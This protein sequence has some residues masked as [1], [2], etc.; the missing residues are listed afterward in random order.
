MSKVCW[1]MVIGSAMSFSD[2][3]RETGQAYKSQLLRGPEEVEEEEEDE[4]A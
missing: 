1:L 3:T 2:A 4:P